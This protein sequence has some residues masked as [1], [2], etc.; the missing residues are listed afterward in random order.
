MWMTEFGSCQGQDMFLLSEPSRL[1]L[2][3]TYSPVQSVPAVRRL[4]NETNHEIPSS[5]E[6]EID[7]DYT[8]SPPYVSMAYTGIALCSRYFLI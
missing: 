3:L 5:A 4:G 7:W 6:A 1:A 2:R 8:S